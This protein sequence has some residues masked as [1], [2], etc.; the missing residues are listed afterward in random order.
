MSDKDFE[1]LLLSHQTRF[2]E[3]ARKLTRHKERAEDLLQDANVR[4]WTKR[5]LYVEGNFSSWGKTLMRH[6]FLNMVKK[7][8]LLPMK[9]MP[10]F[11]DRDGDDVEEYFGSKWRQG[12]L[13]HFAVAPNQEDFWLE[14]RIM[15]VI[16]TLPPHHALLVQKKLEGLTYNQIAVPLGIKANNAK[17][18]YFNVAKELRIL[19]QERGLLDD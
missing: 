19:L 5:H 3:Y 17:Q 10:L 6:Y 11:T 15:E 9:T 16:A 13:E 1:K 2:L 14:N 7:E 8:A 18:R 4:M 12:T